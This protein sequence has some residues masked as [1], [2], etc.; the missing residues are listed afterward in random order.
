MLSILDTILRE[1]LDVGRLCGSNSTS[2]KNYILV[3]CE[4]DVDVSPSLGK[5]SQ[6][7]TN[8]PAFTVWWGAYVMSDVIVP[9]RCVEVGQDLI[10][11]IQ[12]QL[13]SHWSRAMEW[14]I[15]LPFS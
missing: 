1:L 9:R 4:I 12:P 6:L 3:V 8:K 5:I 2:T 10:S 15:R 13:W 14:S 11:Y 7:W